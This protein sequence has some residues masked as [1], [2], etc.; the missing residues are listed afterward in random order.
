MVKGNVAKIEIIDSVSCKANSKARELIKP[1]LK[2]EAKFYKRTQYGGKHIITTQYLITGRSNS[3]G[4]FLTGFLRRIKKTFKSKIQII[5]KLEKLPPDSKIPYLKNIIF[6]EDQLKTIKKLRMKQRGL[7]VYP[8]GSGKTIICFGFL[9]MFLSYRILF[10]CHTLDLITQAS[11]ELT[12]FDINHQILTGTNKLQNNFFDRKS[13]FLLSTVQSFAKIP[14]EKHSAFFDIIVVDEVHKAA[15]TNIQYANILESS[16]APMKIGLT[17]TIPIEKKRA[18]VLE[19][20]F[21]EVIAEL[22]PDYGNQIGII[23]KVDLELLAYSQLN[24]LINEKTY[25]RI[26]QLGI[27]ENKFRN[28]LIVDVSLK[29][30]AKNNSVL[31]IVDKLIH[32]EILQKLFR[33]SKIYVPFVQGI[34]DTKFRSKIKSQLKRKEI[35]LVIATKVWKEGINIP[36][37]NHVVYAAAG[38]DELSIRQY[39]GRGLRIAKDKNRIK[40]TDFMDHGRYLAEHSIVRFSIYKK[41]KW[42]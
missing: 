22:K 2:Y 34:E 21:G 37:L 5:G 4:T 25:Q 36:S 33:E 29:S 26:Y 14:V 18:L 23:A 6:R 9:S 7:V 28:N 16:L 39:M 24:S 38:K 3:S 30:I 35:K 40:L 32:G 1:L 41:Q 12:R 42:I 11:E 13:C 17:A 31:I 15:N 19:G 20:L 27:V 10:L 8:T